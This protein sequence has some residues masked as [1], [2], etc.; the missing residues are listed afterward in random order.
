MQKIKTIDDYRTANKQYCQTYYKKK[1]N[2]IKN[3][4][5][6]LSKLTTENNQLKQKN[7]L[8]IKELNEIKKKLD[9]ELES[10]NENDEDDDSDNEND[11]DDEGKKEEKYEYIRCHNPLFL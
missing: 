9:E 5:E 7:A 4:K 8:L 11:E 2:Q 6:E 10:D 3:Q 1:K